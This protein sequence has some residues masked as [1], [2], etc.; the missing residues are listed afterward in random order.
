[1]ELRTL[2]WKRE[3]SHTVGGNVNW[4]SHYGKK[5]G[6]SSTKTKIEL[7]YDPAIP[8]LSMYWDKTIIRKDTR[9]PVFIAAL[10]TEAKT[11]K[12][13]K[14]PLTDEWIKMWC[15]YVC[16]YIYKISNEDLLYSRGNYVQYL[17][18]SHNGKEYEK[19][20]VYN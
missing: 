5:Y 9:T 15:V 1:M 19:D 3:P 4:H 2:H 20:Y 14:C 10:F 12:Q 8:L 13:P 17:A 6:G 11:W 18:I 16:V 7:P